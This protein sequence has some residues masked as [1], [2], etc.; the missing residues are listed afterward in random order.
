MKL[1]LR[2]KD[3]APQSFAAF[4][5]GLTWRATLFSLVLGSIGGAVFWQIG[6][7]LAWMLGA[8][9]TVTVVAVAHGPVR[10]PKSLRAVMVAVLGVM[11]G[12]SFSPDLLSRAD[13]WLVTLSCLVPYLMIAAGLCYV[14]FLKVAHYDRV[15]AF[16][17]GV[18]G[19]LSEMTLIGG[20]MGGDP[21]V[22]SLAHAAR[23]LIVVSTIP[24]WFQIARTYDPALNADLD[25]VFVSDVS[26]HD[27][28]A[29]GLCAV[30]GYV[31]GRAIRLPAAALTGPML[32][33]AAAHLAGWT[34]SVPPVEAVAAA[35]VV[36]G[37]AIGCR[38][39]GTATRTVL[40][41]IVLAV[42]ALVVLLTVAVAFAFGLARLTGLSFDALLLAYAPGGLAEMTLIAL[43]KHIDPAFV[44]AH[45]VVR[46]ALIVVGAQF[47]FR[48]LIDRNRRER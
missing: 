32:L 18:P 11:L 34:Q 12:S 25:L 14:F 5:S 43:S 3:L 17:S 39:A 48:F 38:F 44:S 2:K 13:E 35:Q 21:R 4:G 10:L 6:M 7:P 30:L 8:M 47:V 15:T 33:S 31:L 41:A 42:G 46:I 24:F 29:L 23:I 22:I 28:V 40:R 37:T 36:L 1:P 20:D 19:G 26:L 45:H 27:V 9:I 16:Y